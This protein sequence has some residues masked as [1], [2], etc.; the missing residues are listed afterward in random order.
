MRAAALVVSALSTDAIMGST[1]PFLEEI[2]S[3][4][5]HRGQIHAARV[6]RDLM[7]GSANPR[8]PPRGR[9]PRAGSLLHPLS[10]AGRRAP[11]SI[12]CAQAAR[13]LEIEANAATDNP[14]VLVE[15]DMIVSGGNFHAEPVAFAADHDRA[16]RGR[17]R[18]HFAAPDRAYGGP[19]A[20]AMT[21]RPS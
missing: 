15:A 6:M 8:K 17:D 2:H 21:C 13:T 19:D 9:H 5:G 10:A 11:V 16:G 3:L 12:F 20:D 14:L 18:R 7:D 4:R 1:A